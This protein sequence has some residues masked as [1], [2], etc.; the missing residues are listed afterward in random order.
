MTINV[1]DV[2]KVPKGPGAA[3]RAP[4][5]QLQHQTTQASA[6]ARYKHQLTSLVHEAKVE[7]GARLGVGGQTR[8]TRL[9]AGAAQVRMVI[10]H[11]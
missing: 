8:G 3:I 6:T 1:E 2:R 5:G 10:D 11:A 7:E 4:E 9:A